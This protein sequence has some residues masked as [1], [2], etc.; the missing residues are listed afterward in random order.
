[1]REIE[2]FLAVAEELH[3]GRAAQRLHLTTA[4]ISQAIRTLERR[5]GAPLFERTSRSVALTAVGA[6]FL[7]R[8]RPAHEQL[9]E[10]LREAQRA[11]RLR[12]RDPLRAGFTSTLPPELPQRIIKA[13]TDQV[14]DCQLIRL[15]PPASD[16]LRWFEAGR[17]DVDVYVGWA[18]QPPPQREPQPQPQPDTAPS[19]LPDWV[20]MG[21]VLFRA[22]RVAVM[23]TRHPLA[24]RPAVDIEELADHD[25]M[26]LWGFAPF[27]D[28]WT[29]PRTPSGRPV[30]RLQQSRAFYAEDV[31]DLL[32]DGT[33]ILLSGDP[34]ARV[35]TESPGIVAVPVSGLPP[36]VCTVLWEKSNPSP[37]V[38]AFAAAAAAEY[39]TDYDTGYDAEYTPDGPRLE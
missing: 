30:R 38:K 15:D 28:A 9:T 8:V 18:P 1:M 17:F 39:D 12:Y 34:G 27:A 37:W 21:P 22:P 7:A 3:F 16:F 26:R 23:S 11:T 6:E 19:P 10:A 14:P 13:F 29:P 20:A 25:I 4:S 32:H 5:V 33:L 36:L 2:A 35:F 24:N 31:P